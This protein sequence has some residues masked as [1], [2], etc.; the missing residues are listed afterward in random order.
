LKCSRI[1]NTSNG[2][3]WLLHNRILHHVAG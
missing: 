1:I 2:V 3:S